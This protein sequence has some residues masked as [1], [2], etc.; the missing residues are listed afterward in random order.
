[1][2]HFGNPAAELGGCLQAT[3]IGGLIYLTSTDGRTAT[4]HAPAQSLRHFGA[5]ARSHPAAHEQGLRLLLGCLLQQATMRGFSIQPIFGLFQGQIYRVM[6]RLTRQQIWDPDQYS[7]IGYC[8]RCGHYQT[9][10]WPQ[11]SRAVCTLHPQPLPLTLSG[12]Q[13]LGPLHD[14]WWLQRMEQLAQTW[15]WDQCVYLLQVMQLEV[16]LPPYF[17]TLADIGHRGRMDIPKRDRLIEALQH[18][19]YAASPTHIN[20]QALKT[21][22][23]FQIC[24]EIARQ[25]P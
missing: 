21:T 13:W 1:M 23:P 22:A 2:D 15:G 24:I 9:V 7:F 11:L 20:P 3:K 10:A 18:R 25:L 6:A 17:F 16:D 14:P 12:P 5:Y 8:H 19:G 4:G